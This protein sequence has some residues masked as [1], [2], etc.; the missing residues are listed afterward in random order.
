M[1]EELRSVQSEKVL[2]EQRLAIHKQASSEV[3]EAFQKQLDRETRAIT[4]K[5][6]AII[7]SHDKR[8]V[9][10]NETHARQCEELCRE[11]VDASKEA[12]RLQKELVDLSSPQ[13]LRHSI[14]VASASD[15]GIYPASTTHRS[16]KAHILNIFLALFF[17]VICG[18]QLQGREAM[19]DVLSNFELYIGRR[20]RPSGA[21]Q[22][23]DSS[24]EDKSIA[25][26]WKKRMWLQKKTRTIE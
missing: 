26:L 19:G 21:P 18:H 10:I 13:P 11:V 24:A 8:I 14:N 16:R 23:L 9:E 25:N 17:G 2:L 5:Y 22:T 1:Q 15:I 12:M 7:A 20:I 6:Q 3:R 4:E